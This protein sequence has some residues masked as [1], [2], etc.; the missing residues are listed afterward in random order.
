MKTIA[1][2]SIA[3]LAAAASAQGLSVAFMADRSTA[4]AGDTIHW[5]VSVSTTGYGST[6]YFGGFVG[7]L[8]S[9]DNSLGTSGN[10]TSHMAG[11]ATT[12]SGNGADVMGINIFNSALLGTDDSSNPY[13]CFEFDVVAGAGTGDLTYGA[14]GTWS[15]FANDGIFTLPDEYTQPGMTSDRVQINV[16]TPG[17]IALLGLGGLTAARRRR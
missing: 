13:V 14:A 3:G 15:E 5:T 4:N 12:P 2:L 1:I 6:A 9:S 8:L 7:N 11:N 10:Y 16:P 17:A